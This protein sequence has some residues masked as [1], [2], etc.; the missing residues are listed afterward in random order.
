MGALL[1]FLL[2][3]KRGLGLFEDRMLRKTYVTFFWT[4]QE[5]RKFCQD[6]ILLPYICLFINLL[7]MYVIIIVIIIII[8]IIEIQFRK[9]SEASPRSDFLT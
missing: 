5:I 2:G 1:Y 7:L 4:M 6:N 3:E 9:F 8:I